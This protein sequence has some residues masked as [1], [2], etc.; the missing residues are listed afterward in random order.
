MLADQ[1]RR[2][3]ASPGGQ[4]GNDSVSSAADSHPDIDS[5]DK[6]LPGPA[7]TK[8]RTEMPAAP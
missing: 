6:P 3:A 8:P 1:Q 5:S 2:E 7:T 4:P